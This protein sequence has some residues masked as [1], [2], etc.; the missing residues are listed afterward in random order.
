[1]IAKP[2]VAQNCQDSNG[3][4]L[5]LLRRSRKV[6]DQPNH[7]K[8]K[9]KRYSHNLGMTQSYLGSIHWN[10]HTYIQ[11]ATIVELQPVMCEQEFISVER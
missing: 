4:E 2:K 9:T 7:D 3:R 1:M 5:H 11:S 6:Y 8:A 10:S